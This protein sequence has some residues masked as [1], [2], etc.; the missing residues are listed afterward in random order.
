MERPSS[1]G[2]ESVVQADTA[3]SGSWESHSSPLQPRAAQARAS[4]HCP[5][6]RLLFI[7]GLYV[8]MNMTLQ[9]LRDVSPRGGF[10]GGIQRHV[11]MPPRSF[12]KLPQ[13]HPLGL[14]GLDSEAS[15]LT[16]CRWAQSPLHSDSDQGKA[17]AGLCTVARPFPVE[18]V[19]VG[20]GAQAQQAQM[21]EQS[22]VSPAFPCLCW[23]TMQ[24]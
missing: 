17:S 6:T 1:S 4:P 18:D 9:T 24:V 21:G 22:T 20:V 23:D 7:K 10:A 5:V 14:V 19:G 12:Q 11:C 15:V 3:P 8:L 13:P 16:G 2:P